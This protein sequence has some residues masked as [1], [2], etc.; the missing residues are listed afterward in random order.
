MVVSCRVLLEKKPSAGSLDG[1]ITPT[2]AGCSQVVADAAA[3][4]AWMHFDCSHGFPLT[5]A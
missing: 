2:V 4:W 5:A 1:G 3:L